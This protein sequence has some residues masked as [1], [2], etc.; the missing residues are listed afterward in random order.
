MAGPPAR[1]LKTVFF[2]FSAHAGIR[3]GPA[4]PKP[5]ARC[6]HAFLPRVATSFGQ[7]ISLTDALGFPGLPDS[8]C[9]TDLYLLG[10]AVKRGGRF[11]TFDAG[12]DATLIPGGPAAFYL[13]P[14]D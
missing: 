4:P 9:L 8:A 3:V 12:L 14:T 1:L 5:P 10:L 13:I 2:G 6:S 11:A 7:M